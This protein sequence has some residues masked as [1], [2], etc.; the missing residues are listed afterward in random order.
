MPLRS[1]RNG[2]NYVAATI[3]DFLFEAATDFF[4]YFSGVMVRRMASRQPAM[5]A[6]ASVCDIAGA[7]Q[8]SASH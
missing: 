5:A 3:A 7:K 6:S 2:Y 8:R 4:Y 1:C